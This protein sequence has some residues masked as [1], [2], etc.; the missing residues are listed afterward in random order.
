MFSPIHPH[1]LRYGCGYAVA[2]AGHD[3]RAVQALDG[4]KNIQPGARA[5]FFQRIPG[6]TNLMRYRCR[7]GHP[8][9]AVRQWR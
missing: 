1:M 9:P 6:A 7:R 2:N 4:Q 5:R 3:A 8:A